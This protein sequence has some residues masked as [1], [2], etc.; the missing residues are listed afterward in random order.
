MSRIATNDQHRENS[1]YFH[2]WNAYERN[3]F[4]PTQNPQGVI[5]MELAEN[6]LCFDLIEKWIRENPNASICTGEGADEFKEIATFQDYHGLKE[7]RHA[8]AKFM[9]KVR[10]NRVKFDP[11][12]IVMSGRATGAN[13]TIMFCLADPGN[14]F[15]VPSPYYPA[16]DRDLR[17]R[18]EVQIV[19]VDCHSSNGFRLTRAAVELAYKKA[20]ESNINVKGLILTNP[21]RWQ[22]L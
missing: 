1:P 8:V 22:F 14:A 7:F 4:H 17:W 16:F 12:R 10:G 13:E 9:G 15:L 2:G 6:Q 3:R 19:P 21:G 11:G 18:T 5:Q 20:Q